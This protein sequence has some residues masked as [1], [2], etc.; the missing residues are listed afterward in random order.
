MTHPIVATLYD[1]HGNIP[2]PID[3]VENVVVVAVRLAGST[4][5]PAIHHVVDQDPGGGKCILLIWLVLAVFI[6]VQTAGAAFPS[7][8]SRRRFQ[9][10]LPVRF[11][12]RRHR[13]SLGEPL[14]DIAPVFWRNL[15]DEML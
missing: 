1:M 15:S 4:E 13:K 14:D 5:K 11:V 9:Q 3:M 12:L 8:A 2:E 10:A 7:H 6:A